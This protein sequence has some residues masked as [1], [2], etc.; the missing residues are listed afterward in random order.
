MI[1]E[2]YK[3]QVSNS[4]SQGKPWVK[5]VKNLNNKVLGI[6]IWSLKFT[7][8]KV[9]NFLTENIISQHYWLIPLPSIVKDPLNFSVL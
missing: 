7:F 2:F 9:P 3:F 4:K 8:K 6:G 5:I 1:F